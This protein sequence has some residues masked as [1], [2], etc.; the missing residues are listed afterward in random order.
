MALHFITRVNKKRPPRFQ[1]VRYEKDQPRE[2]L[3]HLPSD[4]NDAAI[5][6]FSTKLSPEEQL[7]LD[8]FVSNMR[9]NQQHFN[10]TA[11]VLADR[12]ILYLPPE[13]HQAVFKVWQHARKQGISFNP[14]E[15]ML[16]ALLDRIQALQ[17]ERRDHK[18]TLNE[19][20]HTGGQ[21]LFQALV[22]LGVPLQEVA[23]RF[24]EIAQQNYGKKNVRIKKYII[25][26]YA[27]KAAR[28][29]FWYD[30]VAIDVLLEYGKNPLDILPPNK[31]VEHW[32]RL[33]ID[34]YSEEELK[35]EFFKQF[36][37]ASGQK[38]KF[39]PLFAEIYPYLKK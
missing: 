28:Y 37:I 1:V 26:E 23:D 24:R 33:R 10:V 32:A 14:H 29:S 17:E 5:A 6:E 38:S 36:K 31:V 7:A 22:D 25:E 18:K 3:G 19:R 15:V 4:L 35:R 30:G 2:A 21:A 27:K 16:T 39:D 13:F 20:L 9:F 8:N 12:E 11:G 34:N